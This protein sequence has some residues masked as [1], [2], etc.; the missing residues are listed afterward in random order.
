MRLINHDH[1]APPASDTNDNGDFSRNQFLQGRMALFQ[2]GT[3]NLA[4]IADQSH[5]RWGVVAD[6]DRTRRTGERHQRHCRCG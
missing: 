3:Y 1:V 5:F 6:A 2:S 4:A